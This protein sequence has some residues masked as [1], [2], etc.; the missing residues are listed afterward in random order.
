M[1]PLSNIQE[2]FI[3]EIF[4]GIFEFSTIKL[5]KGWDKSSTEIKNDIAMLR[6][7][8]KMEYSRYSAPACLPS[9]K[10]K[11]LNFKSNNGPV[12]IISGWGRTETQRASPDLMYGSVRVSI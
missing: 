12:C 1:L 2:L 5:K 8:T 10:L 6:T 11:I 3:F 7:E 4:E 9:K